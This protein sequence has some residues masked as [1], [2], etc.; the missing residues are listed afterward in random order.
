MKAWFI[1]N[2]FTAGSGREARLDRRWRLSCWRKGR[3]GGAW[4][5][6]IVRGGRHRPL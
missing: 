3:G 1:F 6:Y 2:L 4:E 5:G